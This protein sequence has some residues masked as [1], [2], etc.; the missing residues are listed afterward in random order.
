LK[1]NSLNNYIKDTSAASSATT[2]DGA[3]GID[4]LEGGVGNDTYVVN[5]VGD[6]IQSEP[7]T[8]TVGG[9]TFTDSVVASVSYTLVPNVENLTL[10]SNRSIQ[11]TGNESNNILVGNTGN[12]TLTGGLGTDALTGNA[13]R[14]VFKF[15]GVGDS[16]GSAFD[17][18]ADFKTV[19]TT[20]LSPDK[21]DLAGVDASGLLSGVNHFKWVTSS[22]TQSGQLFYDSTT[23]ILRGET[24]GILSTVDFKIVLTGVAAL[25]I[26]DFTAGSGVYL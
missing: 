23:N 25:S 21:I 20:P 12:N 15:T 16:T 9:A 8:G 3:S 1:G 11:A 13:G 7:I 18:I 17:T 14:D 24:D 4:T 19:A 26:D 22:I 2:L 6:L 5:N 10:A